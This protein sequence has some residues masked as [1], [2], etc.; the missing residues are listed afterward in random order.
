MEHHS[1]GRI[2]HPPAGEYGTL[3]IRSP[4]CSHSSDRLRAHGSTAV[5]SGKSPHLVADSMREAAELPGS[6]AQVSDGEGVRMSFMVSE[7]ALCPAWRQ[8]F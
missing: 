8:E 4:S 1:S 3:C 6:F 5:N 2:A 7:Q